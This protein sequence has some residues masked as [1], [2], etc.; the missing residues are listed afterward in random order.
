MWKTEK[1]LGPDFELRLRAALNRVEVPHG[2][3]RYL[4]VTP[5]AVLRSA[6]GRALPVVAVALAGLLLTAY[7]ATGTP[8][9]VTWTQNAASAITTMTHVPESTTAPAN[10][11][12]VQAPVRAESEPGSE[13]S[14]EQEP[15][16]TRSEPAET[17]EEPRQ[18]DSGRSSSASDER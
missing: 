7:A 11:A 16:E 15:A 6:I 18:P 12:P 8:N 4:S 13:P 3:P 17:K 2:E 5:G 14:S 1:P 10:S 9:P